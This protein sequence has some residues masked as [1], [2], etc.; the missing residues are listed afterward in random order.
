MVARA[1]T[2]F[3]HEERGATCRP[4]RPFPPPS[5][6]GEDL[7][8]ITTTFQYLQ[9]SGW[10]WRSISSSEAREALLQQSEGT[11]LVRDSSHPQYM[12]ALSV[13]TRCGPTSIRINYSRGSFWLD[14][15]SPSLQSFPDVLSLIQ[16]YKA[17][18]HAP[19]GQASD[20]IH[21]QTKADPAMH[22]F[23][24]SVVPLKLAHPLHK[25]EA[26]PSLQHLTRLTVNR[27]ANCPDQLPLP[28]PLQDYLQDYPFHI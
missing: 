2:I 22:A 23:N 13:K 9:T 15:I 5:E 12:L 24:D 10:Y 3:H 26:F 18:G 20:D 6:S 27:H 21:P 25:P 4:P 19:Q 17:S 11:F 1:L 28:K 8:C 14:S 7:R 16:H